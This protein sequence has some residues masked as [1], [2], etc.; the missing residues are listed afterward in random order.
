LVRQEKF[1]RCLQKLVST[2]ACLRK[3][4]NLQHTSAFI[5]YRGWRDIVPDSADGVFAHLDSLGSGMSRA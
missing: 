1:R 2:A 4:M 3:S 5:A